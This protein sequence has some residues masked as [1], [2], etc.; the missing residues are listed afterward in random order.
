MTGKI[1]HQL[2]SNLCTYVTLHSLIQEICILEFSLKNNSC[3]SIFLLNVIDL[4][5]LSAYYEFWLL[6]N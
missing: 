5:I 2:R 1:L 6:H 4:F 3:D